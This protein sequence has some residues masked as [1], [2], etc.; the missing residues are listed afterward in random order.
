MFDWLISNN[1]MKTWGKLLFLF[2]ASTFF[3]TAAFAATLYV[4]V[5]SLD[6]E[7]PYVDWSTAATTIQ[8]AVDAASNGDLIR[9]NDGIYNTGGQ[10]VLGA[11]TN[12]VA[13]TKPVSIQSVNGAAVTVIEGYQLPDVTNGDA[14]MRCVY[15]TNGASLIGFTLTNGATHSP[16]WYLLD[17]YYN[18]SG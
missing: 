12:R 18:Q 13:V 5:N 7:P 14:A 10:L 4:D 1:S 11:V 2:F 17:W 6:P 9:F 15:L 8:D 16:N 3:T